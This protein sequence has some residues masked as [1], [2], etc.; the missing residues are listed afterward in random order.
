M[1]RLHKLHVYRNV[2]KLALRFPSIKR[3]KIVQ[4][5]RKSFRDN[6]TMT[7]ADEIKKNMAIA[8]K[9]IEQMAMYANLKPTSS[10]WTVDMEKQ[11]MPKS[12]R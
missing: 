7:N 2:L 8:E 1:D 4:E 10:N 3:D 6:R 9:G 11:P 5:I 12:E